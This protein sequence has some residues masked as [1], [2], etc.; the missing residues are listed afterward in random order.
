MLVLDRA[1]RTTIV[2]TLGRASDALLAYNTE[3]LM[4]GSAAH[5]ESLAANAAVCMPDGT[6]LRLTVLEN[7]VDQGYGGNQKLGFLYAIEN[8][9]DIVAVLHGDGQHASD[10]LPRLLE[11]IA[12]GEADAVFGSGTPRLLDVL[13]GRGGLRLHEYVVHGLLTAYQNCLLGTHLAAIRPSY[14]VYSTEL[15]RRIPYQLNATSIHFDTEI[16][17]QLLLAHARILELL[18]PDHVD[19]ACSLGFAW[20]L[21]RAATAARLQKYHLV[22]RRNFD[23]GLG[24]AQNAHYRPK[25]DHASTH[26]AAL[27]ELACGQTVVDI[28]CGAGYLA[29]A[30]TAKGCRVIGLDLYPP[31]DVSCFDQFIQC[32][33]EGLGR[34]DR[35]DFADVVLLLDVVEHLKSPEAF[36]AW[37]HGATASVRDVKII[38]STGNVGFV[39]VRLM[40]LLGQ[41][42][43]AKRGIL[44]LTHTRLFTFD[45]LRRVFEE[46]GF[47]V[48]AVRGIPA[49]FPQ[50]IPNRGLANLMMRANQ[51]LIRVSP[52]LFAYQ[53]LMV[54]RPMPTLEQVLRASQA[55]TVA[56]SQNGGVR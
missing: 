34:P 52:S 33:L 12:S 48:C 13:R 32:D 37:L 45:S 5:D 55:H 56:A 43:Y 39:V 15:L 28:G 24:G 53:I 16:L 17:I 2:R 19:S 8:A 18:I 50:V 14:R 51:L 4:I 9:F 21:F 49:P 25:L 31:V 42:N 6:P 29:P 11:P 35:L 10:V 40:L 41:F 44:D 22:Y 26:T 20:D 23:L 30:I 38:V 3:V 1:G 36:I 46:S 47:A 54:L 7:P 27:A